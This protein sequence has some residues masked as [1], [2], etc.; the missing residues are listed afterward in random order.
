MKKKVIIIG[1]GPAG[2]TAAYTIL[3]NST[4][5][6]VTILE[7]EKNLGGIS[8]TVTYNNNKMDL[9]GHRFFSKN[10]EINKL[11]Q[12]ILPLER[13]GKHD[14][15]KDDKVL[16]TRNRVSRIYYQKKFYDYP[17]TLKFQVFKN[18]GLK[19]T[20]ISGLSYIKSSLF[21][22]KEKNYG[23]DLRKK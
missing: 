15:K 1:G 20:L 9:G 16:L 12:E 18:L 6:D 4:A 21:K 7:S 17:L 14:P 3:K 8:K 2:L 10:E 11:W 19:T 22:R 23:E 5:Y 13:K